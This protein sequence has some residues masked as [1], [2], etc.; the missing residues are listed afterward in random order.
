MRVQTRISSQGPLFK[1]YI[2]WTNRRILFAAGG[3][4]ALPDRVREGFPQWPQTAHIVYTVFSS[5]SKARR[6]TKNE[7][8]GKL[9][10]VA[11]E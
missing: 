9:G 6:K 2:G 1:R 4:L 8:H 7:N 11:A 3:K 10:Q 5:H